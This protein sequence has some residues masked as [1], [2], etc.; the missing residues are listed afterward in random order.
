M[1]IRFW[2]SLNKLVY[3]GSSRTVWMHRNRCIINKTGI[4]LEG[5]NVIQSRRCRKGTVYIYKVYVRQFWQGN[6]QLDG[7]IKVGQDHICAYGILGRASINYRSY[8]AYIYTVLAKPRYNTFNVLHCVYTVLANPN[9][10]DHVCVWRM[11]CRV[12]II[13]VGV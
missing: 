4:I 2:P 6:V 13:G 3:S 5:K 7:I 1:Y 11:F 12:F 10:Y 9:I 8:A